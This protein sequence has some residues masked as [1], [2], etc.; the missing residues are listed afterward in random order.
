M[1]IHPSHACIELKIIQMISFEKETPDWLSVIV[2]WKEKKVILKLGPRVDFKGVK[3]AGDLHE[4][5]CGCVLVHM[6]VCVS[7]F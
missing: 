5:L 2:T 7:G 4:C 3:K 1:C 6:H